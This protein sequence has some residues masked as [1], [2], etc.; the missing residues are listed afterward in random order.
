MAA[1]SNQNSR[2]R[3]DVGSEQSLQSARNLSMLNCN[4]V[5]LLPSIG[6]VLKASEMR[7]SNVYQLFEPCLDLVLER[8]E[9]RAYYQPQF[10]LKTGRLMGAEA[11]LRWQHPTLGLLS[12]GRF[13][14]IAEETGLIVPLGEWILRQACYQTK[15]WQQQTAL[16]LKIAVNLSARQLEAENFCQAVSEILADTGLPAE[17]L[18]LELTESAL[19]VNP[20]AAASTMKELKQ[21]GINLA[22]DDFGVGYSSLKYL[23]TLTLDTVKIDRSFIS[24]AD[25]NAVNAAI[26][27]TMI[28]LAHKLGL[29]VVGE[30]VETQAEQDF[31]AAHNCDIIQ[32]YFTGRP[33]SAEKFVDELL[34]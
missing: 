19:M 29:T 24:N 1:I 31:L 8:G 7:D 11:L 17:S 23:Q 34:A 16:P 12:P 14:A 3:L 30:G 32:G 33:M 15:Q 5:P 10:D 13:I 2:M 21:L 25:T 4:H 18:E 28:D 26:T 20:E 27:S 9:F 22:I 6:A